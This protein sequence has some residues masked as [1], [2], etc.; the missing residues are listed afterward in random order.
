MALNL[1]FLRIVAVSACGLLI[2]AVSTCEAQ[3]VR[4]PLTDGFARTSSISMSVDE[5]LGI[6]KERSLDAAYIIS[7]Q[8]LFDVR[9]TY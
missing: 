3:I 6:R 8:G 7:R 9:V 4:A 2:G 1:N 5:M